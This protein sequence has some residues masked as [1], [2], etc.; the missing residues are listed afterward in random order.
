M[1]L[2]LIEKNLK[3]TLNLW[4]SYF[5]IMNQCYN[6]V[7]YTIGHLTSLSISFYFKKNAINKEID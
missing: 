3:W 6:N 4:Q 5:V 7:T 2:L 1:L